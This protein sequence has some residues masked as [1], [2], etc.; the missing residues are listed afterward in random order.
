[1]SNCTHCKTAPVPESHAFGLCKECEKA[2]L[3]KFLGT[4]N[5][6]SSCGEEAHEELSGTCN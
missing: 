6:C 1:M 3:L 2:F 5:I 4:M